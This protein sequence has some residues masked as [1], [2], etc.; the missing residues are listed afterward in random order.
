LP[1]AAFAHRDAP[2]HRS[3]RAVRALCAA[4][5]RRHTRRARGGPVVAA[6]NYRHPVVRLSPSRRARGRVIRM[7]SGRASGPSPNSCGTIS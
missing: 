1:G 2:L 6:L 3:G 4:E 7:R 5:A